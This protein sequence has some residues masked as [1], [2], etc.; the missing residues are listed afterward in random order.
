MDTGTAKKALKGV[1]V[2][3]SRA[4]LAGGCGLCPTQSSGQT[5]QCL[6]IEE[7]V[8]CVSEHVGLGGG[9]GNVVPGRALMQLSFSVSLVMLI[10][11]LCSLMMC[12]A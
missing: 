8:V 5:G 9:L 2:T 11:Q 3:P 10:G 1:L 6:F 12:G 4:C 7:D